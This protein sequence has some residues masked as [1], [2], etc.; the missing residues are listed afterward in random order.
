MENISR[1][2]D[3]INL[4]FVHAPLF[5]RYK[6]GFTLAELLIALAI[7]G[8]IATFTIPKVLNTQQDSK[9]KAIA[10]EAASTIS[11]AYQ[12]YKN[13]STVTASTKAD[14]LTQF[15]NY[16]AVDSSSSFDESHGGT[17]ATCGTAWMGGTTT[18]LRL[19]NGAI[20]E[21]NSAI[22]FGGTA[23]TNNIW[24]YVDPDGKVTDGTTNGPGK[25]VIFHLYTSGRITTEGQIEPNST[26]TL[27]VDN[28]CASCDPPWFSWN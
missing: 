10:K 3:S 12:R 17:T 24:F 6:L 18:C 4:E 7:L 21:Y 25:S 15:M 5:R 1:G 19:H 9:Y 14:D 26:S 16:L 11:G 27:D 28:P 8:V 23:T 2:K 20:L 22:A 13:Q